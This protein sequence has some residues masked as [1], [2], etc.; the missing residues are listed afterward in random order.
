M[1]LRE[2][3]VGGEIELASNGLEVDPITQSAAPAIRIQD[4]SAIQS[5]ITESSQ[6]VNERK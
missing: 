4:E 6:E 2:C 3:D 1:L 5:E